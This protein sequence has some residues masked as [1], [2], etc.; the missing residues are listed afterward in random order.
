MPL[1]H[2]QQ[3][4]KQKNVKTRCAS[5]NF[6]GITLKAAEKITFSHSVTE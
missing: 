3:K 4:D 6:S 1:K 5:E 2:G